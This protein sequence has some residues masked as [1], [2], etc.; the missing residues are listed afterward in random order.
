M[1]GKKIKVGFIKTLWG[2][3]PEMG[4]TSKGYDALFARIKSEGFIGVETPISMVEDKKAFGT[5]LQ[6]HGLKYV[7]MINTCT[8]N[9]DPICA[10]VDEH[11]NSFRRLV[12][13]AKELVPVFINAHSGRDSWS[14]D[15]AH[16]YFEQALAIEAEEKITIYH[17]THRGRILY[18]PWVTRDMCKKF[19]TLKLTA[20]LSHFCV[21]AERVFDEKSG[22]DDDWA[23][24]M[25]IIADRC[26]HVHARVGYAEGPQVPNPADPAY[27]PALESHEQWWDKIIARQAAKGVT[28]IT[29][30]PEHG[31]NGYQ[32]EL[33]WGGEVADLWVVNNWI[34]DRQLERMS[35][36]PYW[37]EQPLVF[38]SQHPID[39]KAQSA[40][41]NGSSKKKKREMLTVAVVA[42]A[43]ASAATIVV[44]RL[45]TK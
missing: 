34:K 38:T 2:V 35:K 8:F 11:V 33:P 16:K 22:L 10:G 4:N 3:T 12:R 21:V 36:Q 1:S 15:A 32:Q 14:T 30:E 6:K 39:M 43:V 40:A 29:V 27:R 13:E 7:A 20:D 31:T 37:E 18:N 26:G 5:A 45:L 42:A 19:P 17:E 25:D 9:P 23:E 24:T 44:S 41:W 28:E